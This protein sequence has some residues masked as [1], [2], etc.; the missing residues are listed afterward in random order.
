MGVIFNVL[1]SFNFIILW[2]LEVSRASAT[3]ELSILQTSYS[4]QAQISE[5]DNQYTT[6]KPT[7][8]IFNRWG[9]VESSHHIAAGQGMALLP[10]NYHDEIGVAIPELYYQFVTNQKKVKFGVGRIKDNWSILDS[11]WNIG[12]WQPRV[13][14]DAVNPEELGLTGL[15]FAAGNNKIRSVFMVSGL[16]FPDQQASY[17]EENGRIISS[18]RWFRA[19]SYEAQLQH[20]NAE[21]YY[22]VIEP[23]PVD[24]IF[25]NSFSGMLEFGEKS[26]GVFVKASYADKPANQFHLIIDTEGI[27]DISRANFTTPI[28]P[29]SVRHRL[30]TLETG[31]RWAGASIIFS[32]NRESYEHKDVPQSWHQTPLQD[33]RYDGAILSNS[34]HFL[35]FKRTNVNFSYLKK[36]LSKNQSDAELIAGN[37]E[38]STQRLQFDEMTGA[39]FTTNISRTFQHQIDF[40]LKYIYSLTDAAE[41]V[42]SGINY[43]YEKQWLWALSGEIFGA[44]SRAPSGSSFISAYRGNDRVVGSMTYVF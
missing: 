43:Q 26:A 23:K 38:A 3:Y 31:Y 10:L 24:V 44:P 27:F 22:T 20:S 7:F 12:I 28:Y 19:P 39:G 21:V 18:N 15:F 33:A 37:V 42:Q 4:G 16:F 35:G 14:W 29:T 5:Q 30:A 25:Q 34:L 9:S 36:T 1:L 17:K 6:L 2:G 32:T 8:N 40:H 13:C 11:H 41:W